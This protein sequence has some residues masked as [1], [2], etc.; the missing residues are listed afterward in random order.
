M[1]DTKKQMH[2]DFFDEIKF[3]REKNELFN[4]FTFGPIIGSGSSCQVRIAK[5]KTSE[6]GKN[7]N[8]AIKILPKDE[9]EGYEINN[10]LL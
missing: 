3:L 1:E 8:L 10:T 9:M 2:D 6:F 7:K 4:K 5:S